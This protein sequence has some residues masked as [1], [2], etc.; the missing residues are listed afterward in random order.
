MPSPP[1]PAPPSG[2]R[3][4]AWWRRSHGWQEAAWTLATMILSVIAAAWVLGL[5]ASSIRVPINAAEGDMLMALSAI[6][7]MLENGWYLVNP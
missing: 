5:T 6:K 2:N 4:I 7:G 3:V 1:Q